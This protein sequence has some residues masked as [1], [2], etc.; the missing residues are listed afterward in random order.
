MLPSIPQSFWE[1]L[2]ITLTHS[3]LLLYPTHPI[4]HTS[5]GCNLPRPSPMDGTWS[6]GAW[7]VAWSSNRRIAARSSQPEPEQASHPALSHPPFCVSEF[8]L[9]RILEYPCLFLLLQLLF[10]VFIISFIDYSRWLILSFS[11]NKAT[12]P[13]KSHGYQFLNSGSDPPNSNLKKVRLF[14]HTIPNPGK[15]GYSVTSR[16]FAI[17]RRRNRT[18]W[19]L[20]STVN[21]RTT[22]ACLR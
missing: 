8:R 10:T 6:R 22:R 15:R 13:A 11:R 18:T 14:F 5:S 12:I 3:L 16:T 1:S 2:L 4:V 20:K 21:H 7:S 17:D 19:K 9:N